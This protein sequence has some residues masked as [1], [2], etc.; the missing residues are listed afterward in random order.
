MRVGGRHRGVVFVPDFVMSRDVGRTVLPCAC[1]PLPFLAFPDAL[2][3]VADLLY[4]WSDASLACD[5]RID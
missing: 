3:V 4:L 1:S 2:D 5:E